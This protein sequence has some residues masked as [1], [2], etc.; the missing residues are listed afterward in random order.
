M[1]VCPFPVHIAAKLA[2]MAS[3]QRQRLRGFDIGEC[4]DAAAVVRADPWRRRRPPLSHAARVQAHQVVPPLLG[5][6][7]VIPMGDVRPC[8]L[9]KWLLLPWLQYGV[10]E[11]PRRRPRL[12]SSS[13]VEH[14]HLKKEH[15]GK[16]KIRSEEEEQCSYGWL[17]SFVYLSLDPL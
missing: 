17:Y 8:H 10:P 5:G 11:N 16:S 7:D 3:I 14:P 6:K 15:R 13:V 2:I 12:V 4:P 9:L 1:I